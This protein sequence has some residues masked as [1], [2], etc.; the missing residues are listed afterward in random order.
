LR[1]VRDFYKR[2][3]PFVGVGVVA[4]RRMIDAV[5]TVGVLRLSSLRGR[6]DLQTMPSL[7]VVVDR[8]WLARLLGYKSANSVWFVRIK[9]IRKLVL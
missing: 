1:V 8:K 5:L 3:D 2:L 6:S 7:G 4:V 9:L